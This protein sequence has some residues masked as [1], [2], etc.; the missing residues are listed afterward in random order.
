[1]STTGKWLVYNVQVPAHPKISSSQIV[2]AA[3]K[4]LEA[5]GRDGFSMTDVASAVGVR[6]PSLY[7]HFSDRAALLEAVELLLR[8]ELGKS[9]AKH[10]DSTNPLESLRKQA[11]AYRRFATKN[12]NGYALMFD[13]RASSSERGHRA[14]IESLAPA[15]SMLSALVGED[16]ALLAARVLTP[17]LHGFVSMEN[18]AAFRMAAGI[19]AAFEHGVNTLLQGLSGK[20]WEANFKA[21]LT[22]VE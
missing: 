15:L 6:T 5:N 17:Y 22:R 19:D 11:R 14:R 8:E 3:R 4:L 2:A 12:P 7:G 1:M 13:V 16:R 18:A 9:L 21:T 10:A 20:T